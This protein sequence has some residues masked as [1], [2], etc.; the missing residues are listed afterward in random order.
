MIQP[1]QLKLFSKLDGFESYNDFCKFHEIK[2]GMQIK[3][4]RL[5]AWITREELKNLLSLQE[6]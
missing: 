1:D 3:T 4:T 6:L 5:I 2:S